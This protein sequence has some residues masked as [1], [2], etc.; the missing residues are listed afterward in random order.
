[1]ALTADSS[2]VFWPEENMY[3]EKLPP[4]R[5]SESAQLSS[6]SQMGAGCAIWVS[7]GREGA[8]ESICSLFYKKIKKAKTLA[9]DASFFGWPPLKENP[10]FLEGLMV[11]LAQALKV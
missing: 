6:L 8:R 5:S 10:H 1:M 4:H 7:L 9:A 2:P 11:F 3:V